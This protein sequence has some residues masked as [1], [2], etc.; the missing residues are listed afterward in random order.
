MTESYQ[1][2]EAQWSQI[3]S[4]LL[5]AVGVCTEHFPDGRQK[6][7]EAAIV[8]DDI[9]DAD[10][11]ASLKPLSTYPEDRAALLALCAQIENSC[12]DEAAIKLADHVK[13]ILED[14]AVA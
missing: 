3:N 12:D 10:E 11:L 8:M 5:T 6:M 2:T 9:I 13:S 1:I 7:L 4:A 14:E